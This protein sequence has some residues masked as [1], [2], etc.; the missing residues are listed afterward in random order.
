MIKRILLMVLRNFHMVIPTWC[1]LCYHA[2]HPEKYTDEQHFELFNYIVDCANKGGNIT[3]KTTGTEHIPKENGFMFFP[4]HQGYFDVLAVCG[5]YRKPFSVVAKKEVSNIPFL[6]QVFTCMRAYMIDRDD[7]RKAMEVIISVSNDVKN[8][9]NFL[10]FAEGTRSKNGNKIGTFKGG[11]FKSATKA[12]CPIVPVALIDCFK[13]FDTKTIEPVTVQ[14][15]FLEPLYYEEYK[16]MK[17][18]KIAE[19][20]QNRIQAKID[21]KLSE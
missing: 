2:A 13:P 19:L 21:E 3:L 4:N 12:K 14:V 11:S 6:K 9:K 5:A 17:T 7:V 8:G 16:D 15:H 18:T 20:V 10:I 1:R